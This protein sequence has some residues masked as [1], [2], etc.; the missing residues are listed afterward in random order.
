MFTYDIIFLMMS[1]NKVRERTTIRSQPL[2]ALTIEDLC[3]RQGYRSPPWPVQPAAYTPKPS[4]LS[5]NPET[6]WSAANLPERKKI[7]SVG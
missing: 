2:Y 3:E 5:A 4:P 1:F 6:L 7:P